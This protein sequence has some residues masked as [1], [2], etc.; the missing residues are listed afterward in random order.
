M[1]L[2]I[3]N[4]AAFTAPFRIWIEL[5]TRLTLSIILTIY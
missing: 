1:S 3:H 5:T 4:F 2:V